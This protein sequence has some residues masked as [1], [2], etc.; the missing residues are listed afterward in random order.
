MTFRIFLL[1]FVIITPLLGRNGGS[2]Y[3]R[4]GI[5]D[6]RY[7]NS[8][9]SQGMGGA[10]LALLPTNAISRMN[11]A[12]WCYIRQT[13]FSLGML[14]EG[15]STT[16]NNASAYLSGTNF[17][18][19]AFAIPLLPQSGVVAGF[20]LTPYSTVN[21]NIRYSENRLGINY[22]LTYEGKGG[23]SVGFLGISGI[24]LKDFHLGTKL[25]YYFGTLRHIINQTF[26]DISIYT[27]VSDERLV[28]LRG[29]GITCGAVY[30]GL[31]NAFGL[32]EVSWFNVGLV[33]S[34]ASQLKV[35]EEHLFTYKT[36]LLTTRD[37]ARFSGRNLSLPASLGIGVAYGNDR[38]VL[39]SDFY[40]QQWSDFTAMGAIAKTNR[41]NVRLGAGWEL[42][43]KKETTL[44]LERTAY[45]L[46]LFYNATYYRIRGQAIDEIGMT[47]GVGLPIVA[48]TRFNIGIEYSFRGTTAQQLQKDKILRISAALTGGELWFVRPLT[49]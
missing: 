23:L 33:F 34:T 26:D 3:S 10:G 38:Y 1:T 48:D 13:R 37:T 22:T 39:T 8:S 30:T 6:L 47:A 44:L 14:Y 36:A 27:N 43:P 21:Y 41:N 7:F 42:L 16:D 46:G 32:D 31:R 11:P 40:Y 4:Y 24:V 28:K 20:G 18:G 29:L 17:N 15:F 49:E 45:R 9:R 2:G 5:G 19:A 25:N 12:A 35:S